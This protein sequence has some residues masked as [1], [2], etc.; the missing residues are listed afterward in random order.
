MVLKFKFVPLL[1]SIVWI[2]WTGCLFIM[3]N[4]QKPRRIGSLFVFFGSGSATLTITRQNKTILKLAKAHSARPRGIVSTTILILWSRALLRRGIILSQ[5]PETWA[6]ITTGLSLLSTH[7]HTHTNPGFKLK[8][9]ISLLPLLRIKIVL[10]MKLLNFL[11]HIFAYNW[12]WKWFFDSVT[13]PPC[14]HC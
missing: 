1:Y 6:A 7:T 4:F 11:K 14:R 3:L 9:S 10:N 13:I 12:I 8:T 2:D 5:G